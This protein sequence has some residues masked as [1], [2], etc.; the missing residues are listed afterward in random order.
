LDAFNRRQR[1]ATGRWLSS[2]HHAE[3]ARAHARRNAVLARAGSRVLRLDAALVMR[4]I[5]AAVALVR[6][7]LAP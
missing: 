7:A 4:N 5:D 1:R 6:A 3:Q 2:R